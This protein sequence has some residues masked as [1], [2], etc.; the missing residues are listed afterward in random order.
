MLSSC[1]VVFS[2]STWRNIIIQ[3]GVK[4]QKN[5]ARVMCVCECVSV[6]ET[7]RVKDY[8]SRPSPI[9]Y[10]LITLLFMILISTWE[11]K[12]QKAFRHRPATELQVSLIKCSYKI[13]IMLRTH[14]RGMKRS[15]CFI[16]QC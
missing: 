6:R 1:S 8:Y 15:S 3:G 11:E 14:T 2:W 12:E 13:W 7:E 16:I 10:L 4:E 9:H 5:R